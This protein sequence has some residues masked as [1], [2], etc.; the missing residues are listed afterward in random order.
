MSEVKPSTKF[1]KN[2]LDDLF[3]ANEKKDLRSSDVASVERNLHKRFIQR[4]L[5][6][7]VD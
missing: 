4:R 1:Y 3:G 5:T 7:I 2:N 6:E